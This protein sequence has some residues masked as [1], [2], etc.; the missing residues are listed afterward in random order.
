VAVTSDDIKAMRERAA[1]AK[2][3]HLAELHAKAA[4][5]EGLRMLL[6]EAWPYVAAKAVAGSDAE[7]MHDRIWQ[8]LPPSDAPWKAGAS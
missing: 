3:E 2:D 7:D 5:A 8:A 1:A 4:E 6:R